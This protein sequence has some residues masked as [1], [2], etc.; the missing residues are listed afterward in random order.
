MVKLQWLGAAGFMIF[1]ADK[2]I[3]IDPFLSKRDK[4]EGHLQPLKHGYFKD[5][6]AIFLTHGHFDHSMDIPYI[7]AR[8]NAILYCSKTMQKYFMKAGV[9]FR[10]I[11]A[12]RDGTR[13]L[14]DGLMVEV[15]QSQH[16]RFDIRL[17]METL[18]RIKGRI[19][20]ILPL[21]SYPCGEVLSFRF[22]SDS[23][24]FHHFGSAGSSDRELD[25]LSRYPIDLL[26]LPLQGHSRIL[27]LAFRYV[28]KLRPRFIIPHH[29]DDFFPPLSSK[30][31]IGPF[32]KKVGDQFKDTVV[33]EMAVNDIVEFPI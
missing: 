6:Q 24:T 9:P 15:I 17:L 32:I 21:L 11:V 2:V 20:K 28:E 14:F 16:I 19:F 31:D 26:L 23:M 1:V 5:I 10:R 8:S 3:L 30:I 18:I 33:R 29:H 13:C 22:T 7:L 25:H 12:V 27:D 4:L